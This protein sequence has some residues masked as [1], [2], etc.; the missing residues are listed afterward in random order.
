MFF[1]QKRDQE[2]PL[3]APQAMS[4]DFQLRLLQMRVIKKCFNK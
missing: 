3:S 4:R 2:D 1:E